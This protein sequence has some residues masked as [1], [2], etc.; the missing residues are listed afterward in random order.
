MKRRVLSA[1]VAAAAF[2]L[3]ASAASAQSYKL[4][5]DFSYVNPTGVW[6]YG[7]GTTGSSFTPFAALLDECGAETQGSDCFLEDGAVVAINVVHKNFVR[8]FPFSSVVLPDT[9]VQ[10]H[11]KNDGADAI[12][13]FT[14]P[15]TGTYRFE[16]YYQILDTNPS[17]VAPKIFVGA[18]DFTSKAFD[19]DG[20]VV[21]NGPADTEAK[22]GGQIKRSS[23]TR[24]LAKRAVVQFGLDPNGDFR[25]DSTGFDVTVTPVAD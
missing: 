2:C 12:V 5:R 24:Q 10:L 21:L 1:A 13:R 6:S 23:L 4:E 15:S 20:A 14:A 25:F 18:R 17:G 22:K 9:G 16:G 11:P 7:Y 3:G 19:E 8:T